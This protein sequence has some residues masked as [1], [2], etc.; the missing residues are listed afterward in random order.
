MFI[1][2]RLCI[3]DTVPYR[4]VRYRHRHR[5]R[6]CHHYRSHQRQ[7]KDMFKVFIFL[8]IDALTNASFYS[9]LNVSTNQQIFSFFQLCVRQCRDRRRAQCAVNILL[10]SQSVTT[11]KN[12]KNKNSIILNLSL[13]SFPLA[14]IDFLTI[15]VFIFIYY[16]I[17]IYIYLREMG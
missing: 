8:F 15:F 7:I 9:H 16:F 12:Y 2:S 5:H 11:V 10:F 3:R 4:Q 6:H 17:C 14:V 13:C 1:G